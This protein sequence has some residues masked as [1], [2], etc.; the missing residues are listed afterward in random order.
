[1]RRDFFTQMSGISQTHQHRGLLKARS[2]NIFKKEIG[3]YQEVWDELEDV[4]KRGEQLWSDWVVDQ[5]G[6][7]TFC[8]DFPLFFSV[9][10]AS[11]TINFPQTIP[12]STIEAHHF[13]QLEVSAGLLK[14]GV[15]YS[16]TL[17]YFKHSLA[18]Q[19]NTSSKDMNF[20]RDHT[21]PGTFVSGVFDLLLFLAVQLFPFV[22]TGGCFV[23]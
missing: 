4:I 3:W 14:C 23:P 10:A 17:S 9:F 11:I 19:G 1:M 22:N 8:S 21:C 15:I 2:F 6:I 20:W 13:E 18:R 16:Y 5:G 7:L 12:F